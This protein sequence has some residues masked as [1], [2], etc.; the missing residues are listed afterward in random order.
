MANNSKTKP[1]QAQQPQ[2]T[3]LISSTVLMDVMRYLMT[4][5]YGE[6]VKLM[7][8]LSTLNQLDKSI[9]ADFVKQQP[10]EANAKK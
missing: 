5:P 8:A 3:Y 7:G 4:R 9:G 1:T 6:V 10:V 2:R